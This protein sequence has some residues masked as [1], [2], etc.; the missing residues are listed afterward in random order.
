M[1][2]PGLSVSSIFRTLTNQDRCEFSLVFYVIRDEDII[3]SI[4][5]RTIILTAYSTVEIFR[6]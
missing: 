1:S 6:T 5:M 2:P 3:R 4:N